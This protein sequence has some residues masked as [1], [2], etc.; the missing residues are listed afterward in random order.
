[1]NWWQAAKWA[2]LVVLA[3]AVTIGLARIFSGP[4][5]TWI[6]GEGGQWV[7]HGH[8]GS[9]PPPPGY[10]PPASE[11]VLP[12]LLLL[13]FVAGLLAA[14]FLSSRSPT[15]AD[16][17]G[18]N[19]RFLG[20][21]SVLTTVLAASLGLALGASIWSGLGVAFDEPAVVILVLLGLAA[22]LGLLGV[23]AHGT[24]KVLE[25]HYDLKRQAALLQEAV[26]SLSQSRQRQPEA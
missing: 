2:A 10:E 18:R 15:T 16:D 22:F 17:I 11:R 4:E 5:D 23:N 21:V 20:A 14:V 12:G 25:A 26:D 24:K 3:L 1:M 9:P 13:A 19:L 8:P 7:A 6:R